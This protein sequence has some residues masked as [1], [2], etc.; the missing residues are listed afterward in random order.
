[1]WFEAGT[2]QG[3][4]AGHA[5]RPIR[6]ITHPLLQHF[7]TCGKANGEGSAQGWR[8][9]ATTQGGSPPPAAGQRPTLAG[10]L[11]EWLAGLL[12]WLLLRFRRG[13]AQETLTDVSAAGWGRGRGVQLGR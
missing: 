5:A 2:G 7:L 6:G 10:G 9:A 13:A 1:M 4:G 12:G 3:L 8:H 11:A